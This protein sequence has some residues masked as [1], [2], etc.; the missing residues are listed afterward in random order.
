MRIQ[1]QGSSSRG[2]ART[3]R[4]RWSDW[5]RRA[6]QESW[7]WSPSGNANGNANGN[8]K[9]RMSAK[10]LTLIRRRYKYSDMM[11]RSSAIRILDQ[12]HVNTYDNNN[13]DKTFDDPDPPND[14]KSIGDSEL[15]GSR[16]RRRRGFLYRLFWLWGCWFHNTYF[17]QITLGSDHI[18][19]I[20][21]P[22]SYSTS[23]TNNLP[24]PSRGYILASNHSSHLDCSAIFTS[25]WRMGAENVYAFGARDYFFKKGSFRKWYEYSVVNLF[26]FYLATLFLTNSILFSLIYPHLM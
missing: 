20:L 16:S 9:A 23:N 26:T 4:R 17:N 22:H 2:A 8:G 14:R 6:R 7:S 5:Q 1:A 15:S 11:I 24:P 19:S 13:S 21:T 12:N 25:C 3:S 18:H 10:K